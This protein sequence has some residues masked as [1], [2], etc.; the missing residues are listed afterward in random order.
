MPVF[1][2]ER[3][4]AQAVASI[5]NQSF[6]DLELLVVND[7]STDGTI[8]ILEGVAASDNRLILVNRQNSGRPSFPK[9]DGLAQARGEYL[10]FLDQDDYC[11]AERLAMLAQGLD[12][13]PEW[14]AVFHDVMLVDKDGRNLHTYLGTS[15]FLGRSRAFLTPLSCDWY[16]CG[17]RFYTFMS[18]E[19]PALLTM[20]VMIARHRLDFSQIRYD[21]Q[22]PICDD[23]DLWFRLALMGEI[24]YL[25]RIL[26]FYRQHTTNITRNK[27]LFYEDTMSLHRI[28]YERAH[29]A[30]SEE[31][32]ARYRVIIAQQA[33]ILGY[34]NYA[35]YRHDRAREAY[36]EA[37]AWA[38]CNAHRVSYAK[39]CIPAR[40]L[41]FARKLRGEI[42]G[43]EES[44][45]PRL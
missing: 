30:L 42:Q 4:I 45:L 38:P 26:S 24:G 14:V 32:L 31:E 34:L 23:T 12:D 16:D 17:N 9:N 21:T 22:F 44:S 39:A 13:H 37:L 3:F 2:G 25:N 5:L 1:N 20:S 15:D 10:C 35:A 11:D 7:G 8:G 40:L 43:S 41:K 33:A 29:N 19:F 27:I 18:I 36:R 28:N 6:K